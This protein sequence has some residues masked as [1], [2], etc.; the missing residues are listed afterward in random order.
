VINKPF[1]IRNLYLFLAGAALFA[2]SLACSGGIGAAPPS[3][4]IVIPV[5]QPTMSAPPVPEQT[6]VVVEPL[7]LRTPTKSFSPIPVTPISPAI[8]ESRRLTFEFPPEIRLGDTDVIRLTLEVDNLGNVTPTAMIQGNI[9]TGNTVEI[10]NLYDTHNVTAEARLDMAG[11]LITPPGLISEPLLPAQSVSF[12]WS[13]RPQEAG[14]YRGTIWLSLRFVNKLNGDETQ[15]VVSVQTVKIDTTTFLGLKA[16]T[17]RTAG[18]LGSIVAG[19]LGFPF[20]DD[21][22]KFLWERLKQLK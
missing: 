7:L 1:S 21:I 15:K 9:V 8:P 13:I 18:G 2:I 17:A 10:P 16:D 12:Y 5:S 22:F 11:P 6:Q 3:P 19:I 20:I 14:S 4:G